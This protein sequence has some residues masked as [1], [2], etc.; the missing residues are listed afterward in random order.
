M[1]NALIVGL[2][3][4]SLA[5]G[6]AIAL[7]VHRRFT[8]AEADLEPGSG[9]GK[10]VAGLGAAL[11][12]ALRAGLGESTWVALE[13]ALLAADVGVEATRSV[14][15]AVRD[16][17]PGSPEKARLGVVERLRSEMDSGERS[18]RLDGAPSIILVVGVNGTGKTTTIAKLCH[19]LQSEGKTVVL[20]A[21][22]TFRAAAREQLET[23]GD[24]LGVRVV[25]GSEGAD[26]AS[27]AYDAV[28][29]ARAG[30]ADVVIIDTAGRL[31]AKKNLMVE[32]AKIHRVAG[33]DEGADEVLLALDAT[34]GQNGLAQ[35]REFASAVPLTGIVLTKLDGTAKGGIV[36]AIERELGVPVKFAGL[37][38]GLDDLV[39]F[40]PE[41]FVGALLVS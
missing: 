23:W 29:S 25:G 2:L 18:L 15:E 8:G 24:R 1:E 38:E 22:D 28:D 35:V 4:V 17:G 31:H 33:G 32:L 11:H 7:W 10:S 19:R 41:E 36:V 40:D 16:A 20:G 13:E 5:I 12:R 6:V 26:P 30:G 14:V 39:P 3:L 21:A 27:V 37:G 9:I 34:A